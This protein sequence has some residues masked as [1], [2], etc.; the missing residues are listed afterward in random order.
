MICMNEI[1]RLI[2]AAFYEDFAQ[3]GDVTTDAIFT[4]GQGD[5]TYILKAKDKGILCGRQIFE[6]VFNKIDSSLKVTFFYSDSDSLSYGDIVA[7]IEGNISSILKGERTALNFISYLSG[8]AS[9][10][11]EFAKAAAPVKILDTRKTLPGY[12][13]LAK[14]AVSCGGAVNHRIGLHD[15]VMIKDNH[16]DGCGGISEAVKRVREKWGNKYKIEVET[17]NL[18]EVQEA[19]KLDIDRIMLDNMDNQTMIEAVKLINKKT[20]VEASGNMTLERVKILSS[21]GL[22]YISVGELTHTV[23]I[24]DFSLIKD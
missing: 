22:D 5:G 14:Y 6:R 23:K 21:S 12:R 20:E 8:I 4:Q 13:H 24:F 19:L 3:S 17:R 10:S 2:D 15:M 7:K 1:N 16:S 9:K 18:D 11:A